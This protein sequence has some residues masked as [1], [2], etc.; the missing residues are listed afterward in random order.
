MREPP[1]VPTTLNAAENDPHQ[2]LFEPCLVWAN[3]Y[4]RAV[5]CFAPG[6]LKANLRGMTAFAANNGRARWLLS[7]ALTPGAAAGIREGTV[8]PDEMFLTAQLTRNLEAIQESE[9]ELVNTLAWMVNDEIVELRFIFS[10]A[11]PDEGEAVHVKFGIFKD[12]NGNKVSFNSSA[13]DG[14]QG[15]NRRERLKVFNSWN[16]AGEYVTDDEQRF[17]QL[18]NGK[19]IGVLVWALP[20][21]LRKTIC[22]LRPV[23]RPYALKKTATLAPLPVRSHQHEAV[24]A[25]LKARR[26]VLELAP[27]TG[28]FEVALNIV[29]RLLEKKKV[30][31]VIVG[32]A[33]TEV[34][35]RWQQELGRST[36]L[37]LFRYYARHQELGKFILIPNNSALVVAKKPDALG[38][39]VKHLSGDTVQKAVIILDEVYDLNSPTMV[40]R[41][42]NK[43]SPFGYR[44]GLS[45]VPEPEEDGG[46]EFVRNEVGAVVYSFGLEDA[47][48]QGL[49]AEFDYYPYEFELTEKDREE[50][51]RLT[52]DHEARRS[53]GK[54]AGEAHLARRLDHV[55]K[56]SPAKVNLFKVFAR[57]N[58]HVFSRA[59]LFVEDRKFG[60]AVERVLEACNLEF[61]TCYSEDERDDLSRFN[62]GELDCLVT[63]ELPGKFEAVDCVVLLSA[64]RG[65]TQTVQRLGRCLAN[66]SER[67]GKRVGVVDFIAQ[68]S[69]REVAA[70]VS[71]DGGEKR[72][73]WLRELAAVRRERG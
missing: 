45:T 59:V 25:F 30:Q 10:T 3:R 26:G 73:E 72:R 51:A 21:T 5:G 66:G 29:S 32:A 70:P 33:G 19:D 15:S 63:S 23:Q 4:D 17:E 42:R 49:I 46:G 55:H 18:W 31:T 43:L 39:A 52:A 41:L 58:R 16:G 67:P 27:G 68:L 14:G 1:R 54:P 57:V 40:R 53:A 60:A 28:R 11:G 44:L 62:T 61:G 35:D 71:A 12:R 22:G 69:G 36:G 47:I 8:L 64:D 50:M 20:E 65:R 34:L 6:W 13:A 37:K 56:V 38:E 2:M 48:R 7:P 9:R 24:E